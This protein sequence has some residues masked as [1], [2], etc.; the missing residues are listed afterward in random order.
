MYYADNKRLPLNKA[1][2]LNDIS[3]PSNWLQIASEEDKAAAG[4]EQREEPVLQFKNEKFYYNT[5]QDGVVTST[6]K[7][8]D[9]LRLSWPMLVKLPY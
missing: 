8:L 5:V 7:D 6:P 3:Y 9:M 2:T 4:I 1:F